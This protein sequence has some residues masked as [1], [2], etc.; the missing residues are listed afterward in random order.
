MVAPS[1]CGWV[2]HGLII[3]LCLLPLNITTYSQSKLMICR[4]INIVSHESK[5][6]NFFFWIVEKIPH[7][8]YIKCIINGETNHLENKMVLKCHLT[9]DI[10]TFSYGTS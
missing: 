2:M 10:H 4:N 6:F 1:S 7:I 5:Q 9:H 8:C 3:N